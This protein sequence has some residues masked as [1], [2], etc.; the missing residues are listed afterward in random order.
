MTDNKIII[1][2]DGACSNNQ[3]DNNLGG[4]GAVM[5]YKGHR[6]EIYGG[7]KNTTNNIME[8]KAII[9]ALKLL[10]TYEIPVEIYTDSAYISNCMNQK[11][12][13]KWI[14]NGWKTAN[15]K[16]VKNKE[17]WMEI[18]KYADKINTITFHKV[19]GHSGVELNEKADE[20]AN[21]GID[22]IR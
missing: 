20:L 16:P 9:E 3:K 21:K 5:L 18:L 1:Y 10:K 6:K 4:Y 15:K 22:S 2:T 14:K 17:L 7:E 11:W 19:P 13:E 12:Y 8:M